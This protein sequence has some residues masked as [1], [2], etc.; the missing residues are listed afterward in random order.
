MVNQDVYS[1]RFGIPPQA[2]SMTLGMLDV[3]GVIGIEL[4]KR[5]RIQFNNQTVYLPPQGI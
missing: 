2:V 1:Q 3:D 5:Y 4:F